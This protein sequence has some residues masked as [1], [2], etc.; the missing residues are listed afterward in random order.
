MTPAQERAAH[1]LIASSPKYPLYLAA[2]ALL[3]PLNVVC[4]AI[5]GY[6]QRLRHMEDA[7]GFYLGPGK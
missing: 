1:P 5:S 6:R 4:V 7:T 2:R 3:A